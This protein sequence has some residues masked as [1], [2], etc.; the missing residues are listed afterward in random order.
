MTEYTTINEIK[1]AVDDGKKVF[2]DTESY[3]VIKDNKA[4]Y[5]IKCLLNNWCCGLHGLEGTTSKNK[6]NGNKFYKL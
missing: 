5:L 1:Q 2:A 6:L 4:Q 3:I